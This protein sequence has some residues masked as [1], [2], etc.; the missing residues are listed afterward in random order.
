MKA[1]PRSV[2]AAK[3]VAVIHIGDGAGEMGLVGQRR[4]RLERS[5]LRRRRTQREQTVGRPDEC[6]KEAARGDAGDKG[7]EAPVQRFA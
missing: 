7:D 1:N 5:G 2:L 4:R 3:G 6:D